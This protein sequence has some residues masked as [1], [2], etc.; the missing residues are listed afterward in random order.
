MSYAS[1]YIVMNS[2]LCVNKQHNCLNDDEL[3]T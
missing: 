3:G 1:Q 2:A